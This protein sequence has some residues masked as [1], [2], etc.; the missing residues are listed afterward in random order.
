MG[1]LD[2]TIELYSPGFSYDLCGC[3]Y[4]KLI[5]ITIKLF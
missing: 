5:F 1:I 3:A 4:L 2:I